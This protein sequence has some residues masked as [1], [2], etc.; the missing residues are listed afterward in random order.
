V[1]PGRENATGGDEVIGGVL[2]GERGV[3][4]SLKPLTGWMSNLA[5]DG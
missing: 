3:T 1:R 5:G 2:A 4:P